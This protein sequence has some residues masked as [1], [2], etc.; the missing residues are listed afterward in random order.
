MDVNCHVLI[1][2]MSQHSIEELEQLKWGLIIEFDET[3]V[4]HEG[5]SVESIHNLL[6][7]S[8]IQRGCF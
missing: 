8:R 3:E 1:I 5:R 6:D 7:L 4:A 2:Q